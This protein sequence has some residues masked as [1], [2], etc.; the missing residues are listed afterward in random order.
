LKRVRPGE[1]DGEFQVEEPR[2]RPGAVDAVHRELLVDVARRSIAHALD[3]GGPLAVD[4]E[5]Y[6]VAL[7]RPR[8]SFVTLHRR[9]EL[10]G[11]VGALEAVSPLVAGVARHAYGAAFEDPRFAPVTREEATQLEIHISVLSPLERIRVGTREALIAAL[12]PGLDGLVLRQAERRATFLPSVWGSLSEPCDFVAELERKAGFVAGAWA[13]GV[14]CFRYS[15]E[16]WS[17]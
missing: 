10:R 16:E 1:V 7:R 12:R 17:G 8:A 15:V 9:E 4:P 11:C 5:A 14:E 6:P 3:Q 13:E 2:E